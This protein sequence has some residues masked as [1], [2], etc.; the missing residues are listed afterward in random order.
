MEECLAEVI[1]EDARI[2][3]QTAHTQHHAQYSFLVHGTFFSF[4]EDAVDHSAQNKEHSGNSRMPRLV[5]GRSEG[6]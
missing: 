6:G 2:Y 3:N 5:Q 1:E 4:V